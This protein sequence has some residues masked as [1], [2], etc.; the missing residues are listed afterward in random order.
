M[1]FFYPFLTYVLT[2]ISHYFE[3]AFPEYG[4]INSIVAFLITILLINLILI[5]IYH[6]TTLTG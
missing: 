4:L 5:I 2:R 1:G 6:L 3:E